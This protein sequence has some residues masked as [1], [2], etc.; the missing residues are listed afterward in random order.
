MASRQAVV[1][2]ATK[3]CWRQLTHLT[4]KD[5]PLDRQTNLKHIS[6]NST[7]KS[8]AIVGVIL[9]GLDS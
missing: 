1:M 5:M 4:T 9:F 8:L 6:R 7:S 2:W 3:E